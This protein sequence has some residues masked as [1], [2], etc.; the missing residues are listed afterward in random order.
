MFSAILLNP[1]SYARSMIKIV[2]I[3]LLMFSFNGLAQQQQNIDSL[4]KVYSD[5]LKA[6][7]N[8]FTR[9]F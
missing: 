9:T 6:I 5:N 8:N 3:A 1:Q 4:R 7:S 2:V